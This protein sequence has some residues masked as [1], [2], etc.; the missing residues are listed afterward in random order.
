METWSKALNAG[1]YPLS[2][3]GLTKRAANCYKQGL[4]GNTMT[5]NP[6]AL[7]V[8]NVVMDMLTDELRNNIQQRGHEFIQELE[9]LEKEFPHLCNGVQGTGLLFSMEIHEK[10]PVVATVERKC[11]ERG[12]GIIHGGKNALRFTPHFATTSAE[13]QLIMNILREVFSKID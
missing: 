8:A 5:T 2:V 1:Q 9:K 11:R 6:R 12:L 3:L 7:E 4:Y 13:V 10:Y